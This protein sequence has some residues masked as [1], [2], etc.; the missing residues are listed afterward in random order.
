MAEVRKRSRTAAVPDQD[1]NLVL[2]Q[3]TR[4]AMHLLRKNYTKWGKILLQY[5]NP[6]ETNNE[7]IEKE[8]KLAE[9]QLVEVVHKIM[10]YEKNHEQV[11]LCFQKVVALVS[12]QLWD[13]RL[14]SSVSSIPTRTLVTVCVDWMNRTIE[15]TTFREFLQVLDHQYNRSKGAQYLCVEM[16]KSVEIMEEE[17][18][19]QKGCMETLLQGFEEEFEFTNN[20]ADFVLMTDINTWFLNTTA[21]L[22]ISSKDLSQKSFREYLKDVGTQRFGKESKVVGQ[23]RSTQDRANG[24]RAIAGIRSIAFNTAFDARFQFTENAEDTLHVNEITKL[25][26]EFPCYCNSSQALQL[27]GE[28]RKENS[29]WFKEGTEWL[30]GIEKK[31]CV[32]SST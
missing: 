21:K 22:H 11:L 6:S 23:C 2:K 7:Y 29:E 1:T 12:C 20:V 24:N 16:N 15:E 31:S 30:R 3:E 27:L 10:T 5:L 25:L 8:L 13:M 19:Y 18:A 9:S 4:A 28:R 14:F 17:K 32:A 26:S